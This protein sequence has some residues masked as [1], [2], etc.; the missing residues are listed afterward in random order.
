[1]IAT[2][3]TL[4]LI[5]FHVEHLLGMELQP[6]Q[7]Y[8]APWV[9]GD[10]IRSL[11]GPWSFTAAWDGDVV[12]CGGLSPVWASRAVG[13]AYLSPAAGA[14]MR[15]LTRGVRFLLDACPWERVEITVDLHFTAGH[16]WARL[17]GFEQEAG[18]LRKAGIAGQDVSLY[19]RVR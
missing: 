7:Q 13:W 11:E 18:C 19:A 16:R 15:P 3:P 8:M 9:E 17:L 2:V 12:A 5:E 14:V 6:A 4:D 10:D 1:M